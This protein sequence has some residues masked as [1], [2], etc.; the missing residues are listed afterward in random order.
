VNLLSLPNS[1]ATGTRKDKKNWFIDKT[2][3]IAAY[4]SFCTNKIK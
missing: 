2:N 3:N 1:T 4:D